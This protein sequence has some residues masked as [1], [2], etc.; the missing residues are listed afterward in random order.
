M[1][2]EQK[3]E[4]LSRFPDLTER[5]DC[6]YLAFNVAESKFKQV[7]Q[8]LRDDFGYS[9]LSNLT[10]VDWDSAE[11]RFSVVYILF[12]MTSSN[13][14]GVNVVCADSENPAIATVSDLWPAA[15]WHER[16]VYDLFGITFTGH[17]D[18]R[19]ILMWDSYPYHPLRKDFPLAGKPTDFPSDDVRERMGTTVLPAPMAG[20]PFTAG[21]GCSMHKME[22]HAKDQSWNEKKT[23]PSA[24]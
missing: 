15:D 19:R 20:G 14:V 8:A 17:P 16:E 18:M 22:P 5:K 2:E 12:N 9:F 6:T 11:N 4:L 1:L 24:E 3:T 7:L 10:A 23:K 13:Y 21:T